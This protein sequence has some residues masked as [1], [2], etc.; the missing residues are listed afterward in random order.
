MTFWVASPLFMPFTA[1][2]HTAVADQRIVHA[3]ASPQQL[4]HALIFVQQELEDMFFPLSWT[5]W[6]NA[7]LTVQPDL[8]VKTQAGQEMVYL[9]AQG[10]ALM[11]RDLATRSNGADSSIVTDEHRATYWAEKLANYQAQAAHALVDIEAN[12]SVYS[13][14]V[15]QLVTNLALDNEADNGS[16]RITQQGA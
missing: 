8:W 5:I 16:F 9:D 10:L 15:Y 4:S 12:P 13:P 2:P 11:A 1:P 7:L 14:A 3:Q 6:V